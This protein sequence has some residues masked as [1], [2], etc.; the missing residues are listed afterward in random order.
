MPEF[1]SPLFEVTY[2]P[3]TLSRSKIKPILQPIKD[4]RIDPLPMMI[5][6][7]PPSGSLFHRPGSSGQKLRIDNQKPAIIGDSLFDLQESLTDIAIVVEDTLVMAWPDAAFDI[8]FMA[9]PFTR[10]L[11]NYGATYRQPGYKSRKPYHNYG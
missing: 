6:K 2:I 1:K 11:V 7:H 10:S 8:P 9:P 4:I 5:P 3:V